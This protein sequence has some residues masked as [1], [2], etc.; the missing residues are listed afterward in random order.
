VDVGVFGDAGLAW[1]DDIPESA[2]DENAF[3]LGGDRRPLTSA[4]GLARMNFFGFMIIE[5]NYAYAFQRGKWLW[6]FSFQPGF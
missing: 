6:Q 3:F 1:R 5:A 4:G 2:A